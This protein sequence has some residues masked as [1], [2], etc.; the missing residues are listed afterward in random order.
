MEEI[1][2]N[3]PQLIASQESEVSQK[4][5]NLDMVKLDY[6]IK[7]AEHYLLINNTS[8]S[9]SAKKARVTIHTKKQ[10]K[11]LINA[12]HE[13]REAEVEF[14]R[15]INKFLALRKQTNYRIAEMENL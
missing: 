11:L 12:E 8:L 15:L 13:L 9:E 1:L 14:N 7:K 3:L 6:D 10:A 4:R 2:E 5:Y